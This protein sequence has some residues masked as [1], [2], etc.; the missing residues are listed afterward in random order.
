MSIAQK[1]L[2]QVAAHLETIEK[3]KSRI[4]ILEAAVRLAIEKLEA[5]DENPR[6]ETLVDEALL[7]L[8]QSIGR[9]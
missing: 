1:I 2:E 5:Y 9:M 6:H 8:N 7:A 3:Q 4:T